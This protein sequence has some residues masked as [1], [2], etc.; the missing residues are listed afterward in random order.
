MHSTYLV[1]T[2]LNYK[3]IHVSY[4]IYMLQSKLLY[5]QLTYHTKNPYT[6]IIMLSFRKNI[7]GVH[8]KS[9][10]RNQR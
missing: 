8:I 5:K 7:L 6:P 2:L 10:K 1:S 9:A 3:I 4:T